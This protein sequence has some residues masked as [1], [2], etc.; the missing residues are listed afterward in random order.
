MIDL[1]GKAVAVVG[2]GRTALALVRLL[3]REGARPFVTDCA[4]REKLE[5]GCR[6]L[7]LLGVPFEC[8]GHTER[9]FDGASL[10]IPSPGVPLDLAPIRRAQERGAE[11]LG[12]M[13]YA[14]RFCRS[15]ILAVTGTNGKTTTT[16]LLRVLIASCGHS[17]LLAGN[18]AFP[19]SAAVQASPA[20]EFIVLEVSSYQLETVQTFRPWIGVVLN[21]TPDHLARHGSVANYTGVKARLFESMEAGDT[22]VLNYDDP[23]VRD[24][25][26]PKAIGKRWFS[27]E[28]R[29]SSG[30]WADGTKIYEGENAVALVADSPLRG[31][32]NLQNVLATLSMI[33]AGEFDWEKSLAGL[34]AFRGVEHRIEFVAEIR[35]TAFYND[36]KSTNI[37]SLKVALESFEVP[38]ILI[39]GGRGKGADYRVLR[40]LVRSRVKRLIVIG[41]DAP[42][43]EAAF[44][45]LVRTAR[46]E[47]MDEAVRVAFDVA[48]PNDVVLL[49]PACAS[50]DM[51]ENFEHR[52]RVF[53]AAVARRRKEIS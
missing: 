33:R 38:V 14:F 30:L 9:A 17:V 44:G 31:R 49:S 4:P 21:V 7:E 23:L 29:L 41:E 52:G 13:E 19:F 18:N 42:K 16:E 10:I 53:K 25:P 12:E 34:R 40:D 3:L 28:T 11:V 47:D 2:L 24:M 46:A 6:E 39:A 50:F 37:D 22:A 5:I 27:L 20:P 1:R 43:L 32:H 35:G 36:S 8:G 51:Y 45:D 48:V 15:R 26:A